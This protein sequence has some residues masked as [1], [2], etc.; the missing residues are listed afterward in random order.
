MILS[1]GLF[2]DI[3]KDDLDFQEHSSYVIIRVA[4]R[5]SLEDY[6][7]IEQFYGIELIKKALLNA[8][9]LD[10]KTLSFFSFYLKVDKNEFR[11]S[12]TQPFYL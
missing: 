7:K 8:P 9:Y 11:C 5:G 12:T 2:W 4:Q 3:D 1:K 10:E 6:R